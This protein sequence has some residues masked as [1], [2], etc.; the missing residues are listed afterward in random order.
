MRDHKPLNASADPGSTATGTPSFPSL[1]SGDTAAQPDETAAR[2]DLASSPAGSSCTNESA[3]GGCAEQRV[4]VP[5][6]E[7][8]VPTWPLLLL[9][10]P[11]AIAVWSGWVGIGEMTGFGEIRPLP[12]IW[13]SLH[14]DTA[15]TLPVG[16]E[17]Y[18]AFALHAWLTSNPTVSDRTHRFA[19]W[20]AIAA[21]ILGMSGQVAYHLL[22]Q[23]GT[24]QAPWEVT[25]L[26]AC[27]PVAVLG[28]G[29]V[30][31]HL[32]RSDAAI[33]KLQEVDAHQGHTPIG[34]EQVSAGHAGRLQPPPSPPVIIA[35][36]TLRMEPNGSFSGPAADS[37]NCDPGHIHGAQDRVPARARIEDTEAAVT[38]VVV[39]GRPISRR[40]LRSAGL[41]GSNADLGMVARRARSNPARFAP[42]NA[43]ALHP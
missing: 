22:N 4:A 7:M 39:A 9:A 37:L 41:H 21:M 11:A 30:L 43:P 42:S 15:V 23:A 13:N 28:M 26:V 32:L 2:N 29:S 8:A 1:A 10:L 34:P 18:A 38:K 16:V 33:A 6:R 24:A 25:T 40:S 19:R 3:L 14:L 5:R 27:L 12:G 36:S 31:A 17:A 20:S 35:P